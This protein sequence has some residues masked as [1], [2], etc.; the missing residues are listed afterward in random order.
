MTESCGRI[1]NFNT[2]GILGRRKCI[3][4]GVG[5]RGGRRGSL[6]C[7]RPRPAFQEPR[8]AVTKPAGSLLRPRNPSWLQPGEGQSLPPRCAGA[9]EPGNGLSLPGADTCSFSL[10][11]FREHQHLGSRLMLSPW[12]LNL[13]THLAPFRGFCTLR[14]PSVPLQARNRASFL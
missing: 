13:S 10:L 14:V 9:G 5:C 3:T 2:K 1:L 7:L 6:L 8:A 4:R 12:V 11:S